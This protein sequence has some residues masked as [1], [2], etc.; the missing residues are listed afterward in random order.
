MA[1]NRRLI[2]KGGPDFY[3]TPEWATRA[4]MRKVFFQGTILEPC[5]GEGDMAK[6]LMEQYNVVSSDLYYRGFG[7][8]RDFFDWKLPVENIVTNPPFNIAEK[9]L[10]HALS[11]ATCSVCLLLRL[12]FLESAGR[13]NRCFRDNPPSNV[14]VFSERLSMYPKGKEVKGGGTTSYAWFVWDNDGSG[15]Q[16]TKLRWIEPGY[17]KGKL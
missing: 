3:P 8:Q 15:L 2:D 4:L 11:L 5:C 14:F 13:Y 9:I 16:D 6:V 12:A 7:I 10:E 17:K 1:T